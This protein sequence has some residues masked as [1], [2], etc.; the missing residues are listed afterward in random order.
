MKLTIKNIDRLN[1][2][3]DDKSPFMTTNPNV[4]NDRYEIPMQYEGRSWN[5]VLYRDIHPAHNQYRMLVQLIGTGSP[6]ETTA[7]DSGELSSPGLT[8]SIIETYMDKI[9]LK[10]KQ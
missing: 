8:L 5:V 4:L 1:G 2:L 9:I 6:F 3:G 7:I 10:S